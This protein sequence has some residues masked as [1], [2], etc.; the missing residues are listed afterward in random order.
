M[1]RRRGGFAGLRWQNDAQLRDV[2]DLH[3]DAVE[4]VGHVDFGH[5]DGSVPGVGVDHGAEDALKRPA[6][7]H[8]V[9]GRSSRS[10]CVHPRERVVHDESWAVVSLRDDAQW[11]HSQIRQVSHGF[12]WEDQ[13]IP[14]VAEVDHLFGHECAFPGR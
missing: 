14:L 7:L 10:F 6:E 5:L 11:G 3:P 12:V 8:G 2:R 9:A 1:G 4:P 13:P